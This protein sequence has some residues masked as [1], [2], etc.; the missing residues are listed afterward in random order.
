MYCHMT[1]YIV[2]EKMYLLI[3]LDH[4]L[5][6][7][8]LLEILRLTLQATIFAKSKVLISRS[9]ECGCHGFQHYLMF[10]PDTANVCL[11]I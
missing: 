2:Y 6:A 8:L 10:L 3:Y 9:F 11:N 7:K 4:N 1:L 5:S